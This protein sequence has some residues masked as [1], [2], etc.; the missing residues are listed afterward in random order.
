MFLCG[1]FTTTFESAQQYS[2]AGVRNASVELQPNREFAHFFHSLGCIIYFKHCI[3]INIRTAL[4]K[5]DPLLLRTVS[6]DVPPSVRAGWFD[7]VRFLPNQ[8]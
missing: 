8:R 2:G 6:F 4:N 7:S 5:G 1:W 3:G